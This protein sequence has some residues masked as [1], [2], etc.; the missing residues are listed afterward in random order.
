VAS[1]ATGKNSTDARTVYYDAAP[2]TLAFTPA[3]GETTYAT[4]VQVSGTADDDAGVRKITVNGSEVA[5]SVNTAHQVSFATSISLE[6]GANPID[7][8]VT[9]VSTRT[10]TATHSVTRL[11]QLPTTLAVTT[12]TAMFGGA[13]TLGARLTSPDGLPVTARTVSFTVDGTTTSATT[14]SQ[15]DASVDVSVAGLVPGTYAAGIA[16][17]FAGDSSYGASSGVGILTIT[18]GSQSI[19][20]DPLAGRTYGD[21]PFAIGAAATSGLPV[22]FTASGDCTVSAGLVH[23]GAA[24]SCT[25]GAAQAG[26]ATYD[27]A[28]SVF[29][30]FGILKATPAVSVIGGAFP[31][32]ALAHAA[33]GAVTGI[34][35]A[36]LG[37]PAFSYNGNAAVPLD[38]GRYS[39]VGSFAGDSNYTPATG[40]AAITIRQATATIVVAGYSGMYD[41]A[42]HGATGS[43]AGVIGENLTSLLTL[44]GTFTS[45]PGGTAQWTFAGNG[46]YAPAS[47]TA[48]VQIA[49][50]LLTVRADNTTKLLGAVLP[51]FTASY[52]GFVGADGVTS[53]DGGLSFS[54]S[55]TATDQVG[56]YAVVP[57]G[58]TSN[59]YTI[60]YVP[61]ALTVTYNVCLGS[62]DSKA[63]KSG[64]TIPIKLSICSASGISAGSPSVIVHAT[65]LVRVSG[66]AAGDVE[67]TVEAN[68]DADFRLVGPSSSYMFNFKTTGLTTGTYNL[69]FSVTRDPQLHGVKFQIR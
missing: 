33:T 26:N 67:D 4:S 2:P 21:A 11:I 24:G 23:L 54:T 61:G 50:R 40:E 36:P 18:K 68:P 53:L 20:F 34:G 64:S 8:T 62:D 52:S 38:A 58:L 14:D 56:S 6:E 63:H 16:A 17:S 25:I 42:A 47:G 15:G 13:A 51:V 65:E 66:A 35:G 5:F 39:V 44:G 69:I 9:D 55:A 37:T 57:G 12:A 59:N 27:A 43:A 10:T 3:D 45:V 30:T 7:V 22:S 41:G 28:V 46:N 49:K 32:D 19:A 60:I 31:Y 1:D 29:R 48:I